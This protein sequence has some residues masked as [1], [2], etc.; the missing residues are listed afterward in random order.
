MSETPSADGAG[1]TPRRF[2]NGFLKPATVSPV[3]S[4]FSFS[5]FTHATTVPQLCTSLISDRIRIRDPEIAPLS[6]LSSRYQSKR[7]TISEEG[8]AKA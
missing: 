7:I 6:S 2:D 1:E 8:K 5:D 4:I 3:K